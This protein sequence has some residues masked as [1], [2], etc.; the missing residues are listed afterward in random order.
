MI[1]RTLG[2]YRI[3]A[4]LGR[5]GMGEVFLARDVRLER[6]VAVKTLADSLETDPIARQRL[7][8]EAKA[9]AAIDHP[10]VCKIYDVGE[11]DG[12]AFIAMEYVEGETLA[13]QLGA[14]PI[15]VGAAL[16]LALEISEALVRAHATGVVHRDLKPANL[17]VGLDGHV[18]VMDFGLAKRMSVSDDSAAT[19]HAALTEPGTIVGTMDYASPEQLRGDPVDQRSDLFSL[20]VVLYHMLAG[21]NPFS[22]PTSI[23]SAAAILHESPSP[24]ALHRPN[25]PDACD[26]LVSRL[27]MRDR[28]AR[29]QTAT[30]VEADLRQI[31]RSEPSPSGAEL[32]A[33]ADGRA[34][35]SLV[36]MPTR[37]M[38]QETNSFLAEAI[39][40][41]I[42]TALLEAGAAGIRRPPST[43]EVERVGG[44]LEKV[45]AIYGVDAYVSSSAIA[46]D[47]GLLLDVQ[48]VDARTRNLLWS[49]S[50][51]GTGD[52]YLDAIRQAA[53]GI[54]EALKL[55]HAPQ[56]RNTASG[57]DDGTVDI[58]VQRGTYYFNLFLRRGRH[59]DFERALAAFGAAFEVDGSRADAAA[60]IAS[61]HEARLFTGAAP[62]DV[63]PQAES[64]AR[65]ALDI[66]PRASK[67]WGVLSQ[68]TAVREPANH[69]RQLEHALKAAAFGPREG[70]PHAQLATA[71][72]HNSW[73][74]ALAAAREASRLDPLVL[75][76]P[77]YEAACLAALGREEEA[78]ARCDAGLAIEPD[79]LLARLTK[80]LLLA[81]LGRL[82][83]SSGLLTGLEPMVA[84]RQLH[85][86]WY[87][88][89]QHYVAF[90]RAAQ[91]SDTAAMEEPARF[92]ER[93][94]RGEEPFPRWTSIT[95]AVSWLFAHHG[96]RETA[97]SI[98]VARQQAGYID[99]YDHLVLNPRMAILRGDQRIEA[100]IVI[101]RE[102]FVEM[103]TVLKRARGRGEV[104][105]Y[106]AAALD[107]LTRRLTAHESVD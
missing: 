16:R 10:Y 31:I 39:P 3:L 18:K 27:L 38:G 83:E 106:L 91:A 51:E 17:M 85:P 101:A 35:G 45:A 76:G 36:V 79:M 58:L 26:R 20:G 30:E 100:Q 32:P 8:S 54:V 56:P 49:R 80:A 90:N 12:L 14:G 87:S 61:L 67:A 92:L 25:V 4:R 71:L 44:D 41:L 50:V 77:V 2:Q 78:V 105:P 11:A 43:V 68:V 13:R 94:A 96:R 7:L 60:G 95:A 40:N 46:L 86:V 48:I 21:V 102:R 59:G 23:E 84:A 9:A 107:D 65:R 88:V 22:R 98:M 15:A 52:R 24:V 99:P 72:A 42:S 97:I 57:T 5:G 64:W 53:G 19:V 66:D 6:Q 70:R 73:E 103:L 81:Y 55:P 75:E 33:S 34:I 69:Q 62:A 63:L 47:G 104:P 74:L 28:R 1:G 82:G 93:L 89:V 29:Y 37:V